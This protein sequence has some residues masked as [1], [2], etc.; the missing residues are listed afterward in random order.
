MRHVRITALALLVAFCVGGT[1]CMSIFFH[2]D[3]TESKD[4]RADRL[5]HIFAFQLIEAS[6]PVDLGRECPNGWRTL[7]TERGPLALL[8][9]FFANPIYGPMT[10]GVACK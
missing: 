1:G 9:S 5:H 7:K 3:G 2:N 8:I 4:T 10:T 6:D